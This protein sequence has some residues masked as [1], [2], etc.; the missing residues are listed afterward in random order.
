MAI[1]KFQGINVEYRDLLPDEE[2]LYSSL[3][4][5]DQYFRKEQSPF[6][7]E[8]IIAIAN[9]ESSYTVAHLEWKEKQEK[10]FQ[11]GVYAS[12]NGELKYITGCYWF[13]INYWTLESGDPIE[14]REIDRQ[15]FMLYEYCKKSNHVYGIIR[16]KA[17]RQGAT[18]MSVCMM[19]FE[20]TR[21]EWKNCG[22]VSKTG[23]DAKIV[24]TKML[25]LG[26]K[27]LLPCF[28]PEF[29][30]DDDS[31]SVIR[32]VKPVEKRKKGMGSIKRE[33]LNSYIDYKPTA[34]N[35]Y[36]SQRMS[37]ILIDENGKFP[38]DVPI[39]DY[40]EKVISTLK[41]G[42]HKVGFALLPTTVNPLKN[43]GEAFKVLWDE[44]NQE[45]INSKTGE[46]YG[47]HT[48]TKLIRVFI[49]AYEGY[50]GY[51]DKY[52]ESQIDEAK[53]YILDE[54]SKKKDNALL[55]HRQ[56]YPVTEVDM[57]AFAFGQCE[58]NEQN[59]LNQI[60]K[61]NN[62]SIYLRKG[63][64]IDERITIKSN[65]VDKKD[66]IDRKINF[67]DDDSGNWLIYEMPEKPND[68]YLFNESVTPKNMIMYAAG[69]DTFRIGFAEDGSKGTICIFKKSNV[70]NGQENGCY[71][72]AMY[73]GRPRL[74]QFLYDE[75]IKACLWY[76]CKVNIE[77]SAGDFY[78]GY[79]HEKYCSEILY[80]TPAR[81]PHNPK[82]KIKPGTE[83]ASPF[84]LAAQLEA[85]KIYFDGNNPEVYNGNVH[86]VVFP[87]LLKQA[88]SYQHDARTP[89]DQIIGLMMALLP[90]LKPQAHE[91]TPDQKP[92]KILPQYKIKLPA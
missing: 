15:Y 41:R 13:Y 6:T 92:I 66:R 61:L 87:D 38:N 2:V 27:A 16:G 59:I 82:Q 80:W 77:I 91:K 9:K 21:N 31:K 35:S 68:F 29:D 67:M 48:P 14:Y 25:M 57:F 20:A 32:F 1:L 12:I 46:P 47:E 76:G 36:D 33:G 10:I 86:R 73:C 81:D 79:F 22:I 70:V 78:Y 26:F 42:K 64:L 60:E 54:R 71:P 69:V 55:I 4:K 51:V 62:E 45:A 8:D 44:S 58:F 19:I 74:I 50:S 28:Q 43:G 5:E 40:W 17:R 39:T 52:G 65:I 7:D 88:L 72:V 75:V 34:L 84:E 90:V 37:L 3:S 83:T 53:A 89:Y 49:P 11:N 18:S 63:R 23:E 24:F 30:S 85:A 56:E